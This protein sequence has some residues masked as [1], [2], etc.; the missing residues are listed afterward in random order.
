MSLHEQTPQITPPRIPRPPQHLL[1]KPPI[2]FHRTQ[3]LRLLTNLH[4]RVPPMSDHPPRQKLVVSAVQVILPQ[5]IVVR[6]PVQ[7]LRIL[8]DDGAIGGGTSGK[9]GQSA[10]DVCR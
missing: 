8:E 3:Q 4:I 1:Q 5:P 6:E 7:E 10:V 2:R 9:T